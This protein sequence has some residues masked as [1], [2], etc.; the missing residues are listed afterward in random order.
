MKTS[1][2]YK[3]KK[4]EPA[5]ESKELHDK[6]DKREETVNIRKIDNGYIVRRSWSQGEGDK[7]EFKEIEQYFEKNPID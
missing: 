5:E 1:L 7:R 6:L 2:G 3:T 4:D